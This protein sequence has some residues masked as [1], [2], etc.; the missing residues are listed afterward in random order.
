M[1][2]RKNK[3]SEKGIERKEMSR[4]VRINSMF[5]PV[6]LPCPAANGQ[7]RTFIVRIKLSFFCGE[8]LPFSVLDK[9]LE[10]EC[11]VVYNIFLFLFFQL[12][13]LI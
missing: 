4:I 3:R 12:G 1:L 6:S 2:A 8:I 9:Y 5:E 13:S 7:R 10:L 11:I